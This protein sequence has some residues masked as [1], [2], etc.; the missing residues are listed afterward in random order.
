MKRILKYLCLCLVNLLCFAFIGC[1]AQSDYALAPEE[2]GGSMDGSVG[3]GNA[4]SSSP[5]VNPLDRKIIYT[6][7]LSIDCKDVAKSKKTLDEQCAALGGYV[8]NQSED[9]SNGKCTYA[10]ITYR[11]PTEKLNEFTAQAEGS[12]KVTNK[13]LYSTDITTSYVNASAQKQSLETRKAALQELLNDAS[14]TASDRIMIINEISKV[15][16]EL[17]SIE[18]LLTQYDSMV[19]YSTVYITLTGEFVEI[20]EF[21]VSLAV[22][23]GVI[24]AAGIFCAIFFPLRYKKKRD[25]Q[26]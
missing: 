20:D 22:V 10:Y 8:Q 19:D 21:P 23:I 14:I 13:S 12:G 5:V 3:S 2:N 4:E 18:L 1:G 17:Q 9:Y 15:D 25:K 6:V 11:I 16:T 7:R 26:E 24:G